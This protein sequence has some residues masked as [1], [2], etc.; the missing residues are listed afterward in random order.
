MRREVEKLMKERIK[1]IK[2]S[3]IRGERKASLLRRKLRQKRRQI[4][5][6]NNV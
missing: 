4:R 1:K 2:E 3:V 5:E 6:S